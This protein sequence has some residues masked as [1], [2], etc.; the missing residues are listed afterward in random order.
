MHRHH[1]CSQERLSLRRQSAEGNQTSNGG[2]THRQMQRQHHIASADALSK[3]G[4]NIS[5]N[6]ANMILTLHAR[7]HS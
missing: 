3:Q 1:P 2:F 5:E 4:R 6:S 7:A